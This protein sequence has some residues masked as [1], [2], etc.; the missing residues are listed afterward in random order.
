MNDKMLEI[1]GY[2]R[3]K[4]EGMHFADIKIRQAVHKLFTLE[5]FIVNN[6]NRTMSGCALGHFVIRERHGLSLANCTA[7]AYINKLNS[8]RYYIYLRL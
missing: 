8:I 6:K 1:T 3:D 5:F 7:C 2:T 4:L